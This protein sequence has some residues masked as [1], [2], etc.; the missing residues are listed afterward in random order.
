MP[1]A[2]PADRLSPAQL[3]ALVNAAQPGTVTARQI[4]YHLDV[5]KFPLGRGRRGGH[6]GCYPSRRARQCSG[7]RR[8]QGGPGQVRGVVA[9]AA[10]VW[11]KR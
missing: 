4:S 1:R 5:A 2:L 3:A 7:E 6:R 9:M 8:R 11:I 10:R